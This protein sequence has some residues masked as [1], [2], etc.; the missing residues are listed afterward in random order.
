MLELASP[1]LMN[2]LG[3]FEPNQNTLVAA[4]ASLFSASRPT[5]AASSPRH[6]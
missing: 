6:I 2:F 1:L 4:A 3:G 5:F